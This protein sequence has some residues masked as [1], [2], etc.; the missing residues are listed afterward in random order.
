[1]KRSSPS[2][3]ISFPNDGWDP[4]PRTSTSILSRSVRVLEPASVLGRVSLSFLSHDCNTNH[5]HS[6]AWM[7]LYLI[8]ANF[9]D[10]L[11]LSLWKTD[12]YTTQWRDS[13]GTMLREDVKVMVAGLK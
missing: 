8:F 1:M 7:E 5:H 11:D 10:H 6:L 12:D 13:G 3:R 2:L 9:F 4:M